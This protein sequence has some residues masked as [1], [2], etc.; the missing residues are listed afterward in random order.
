MP[1]SEPVLKPTNYRRNIDGIRGIAVIAV[2]LF[3]LNKNLLPGGFTGVDIFFVLSGYLI[4]LGIY[5]SINTG[6][7]RLSD[8][9]KRR[10]KRIFPTM[11]VVILTTLAIAQILYLPKDTEEFARTAFASTLSAANIYF[12]QFQDTAHFAQSSEE[13]PLLHLW[14]FANESKFNFRT[15]SNSGCPLAFSTAKPFYHLF[16][17]KQRITRFSSFLLTGFCT[18]IALRIFCLT[19]KKTLRKSAIAPLN[20]DVE[21]VNQQLLTFPHQYENVYYYDINKHLCNETDCNGYNPQEKT[22]YPFS[23]ITNYL[24]KSGQRR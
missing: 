11:L 2:I 10:I 20:K 13:L 22:P 1:K 6:T 24:S 9:F 5:E 19:L 17:P 21:L 14:D 18:L 8:F 7:F 15:I 4:S 3:H 12:W 16:G 23:L